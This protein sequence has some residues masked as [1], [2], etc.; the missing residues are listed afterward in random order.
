MFDGNRFRFL[1][2][3]ETVAVA[4]DWNNPA[5]PRLW[6]YNLHYFDDLHADG[7]QGRQEAHRALIAQWIADNRREAGTGWEPYCL[8]RRIVNWCQW[9]WRD[10]QFDNEAR[11]SL[12]EQ[13][14]SLA[15][16]VETHLLGNHLIA[17]AKALVFAGTFFENAEADRWLSTGVKYLRREVREQILPDG[18]HFERSPMYHAIILEDLLDVVQLAELFPG[19]LGDDLVRELT[20]VCGRMVAW[21]L[22]LSHPDGEIAFFNDSSFGVARRPHVLVA[23]AE[24]LQCPVLP[25]VALIESLQSSGY[26]RL[27]KGPAVVLA[28]V[29]EIGPDYLPGHAHADTL[30]F[31]MSLN[32]QRV[33]VNSGTSTYAVGEERQRQRGTAAHNT[34][35]VDDA[36]SSEVW[37]SFRVARRARP[38]PVALREHDGSFELTASHDGYKRLPG[39]VLHHRRWR[40]GDGMLVIED[41][42]T[43]D[44]GRANGR[45]HL[46]PDTSVRQID[47]QRVEIGIRGLS[48]RVRFDDC[49]IC[50]CDTVWSPEFG[51]SVPSVVI[52]AVMDGRVCRSTWQWST[53][54]GS[55]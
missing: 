11:R 53:D 23:Y 3:E 31:E 28:D 24:G 10:F 21:L 40:L 4:S 29:G 15:L 49:S 55:E 42:L 30:S 1:N 46:H 47:R 43:G 19:R 41:Q 26:V 8:S 16:Q 12:V 37:S 33:L 17:N 45:W 6:L 44:Y 51:K 48:M 39:R 7:S 25:A 35:V 54:E 18:G 32:G 14:R 27:E 2:R 50:V 20:D 36:D 38:G 13:A 22:R 9:A 34:V 5:W 52:D